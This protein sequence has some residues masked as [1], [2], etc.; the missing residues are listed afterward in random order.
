MIPTPDE[1]VS[2]GLCRSPSYSKPARITVDGEP[3]DI[4]VYSHSPWALV[5]IEP[6]VR[7]RLPGARK[8]HVEAAAL[9]KQPVIG[10]DTIAVDGRP[11]AI[12]QDLQ[13]TDEGR[14]E[15]AT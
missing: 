7:I 15:I 10:L 2:R 14:W 1:M 5:E 11:A 3:Y 9:P 12:I 8:W 13:D 4:R 6:G